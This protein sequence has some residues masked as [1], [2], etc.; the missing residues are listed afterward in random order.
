MPTLEQP[1]YKTALDFFNFNLRLCHLKTVIYV[2]PG[3]LP[4][5]EVIVENIKQ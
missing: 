5:H 2:I 1:G 4:M 3:N